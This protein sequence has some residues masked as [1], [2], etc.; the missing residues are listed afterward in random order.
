MIIRR[1]YLL[2]EKENISKMGWALILRGIIFNLLS[3]FLIKIIGNEG[4]VLSISSTIAIVPI[5]IYI[6]KD[7]MIENIK[8]KNKAFGLLDILFFLGI[9][10]LF[11]SVFSPV[12]DNVEKI[13]N[14]YGFT[15][16]SSTEAVSSSD[17][18]MMIIYIVLIAPVVE[19]VIYRAVVMRSIEKYSPSAAII[20][21]AV[22]FGTMHKN[23]TQTPAS[24]IAGLILAY[25]A[26]R[27]SIKFSIIIH[28]LNNLI[29]QLARITSKMSIEI[30]SLYA[31]ILYLFILIAIISFIIIKRRTIRCYIKN[32]FLD[33]ARKH[34]QEKIIKGK[35]TIKVFFTSKSIIILIIIDLLITIYQIKTIS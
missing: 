5:L 22:I 7:T 32:I 15:S 26:Y 4:I 29:G 18:L 28:I 24:I 11:S 30:F 21:S 6:G 3:I 13:L 34:R 17:S 25:A 16:I 12:F 19:E 10:L 1:E 31:I 8:K 35:E 27:Y 33:S 9:I 23:I 2:H 14:I 20:S